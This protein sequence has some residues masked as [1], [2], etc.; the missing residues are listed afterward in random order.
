MEKKT[1]AQVSWFTMLVT[2]NPN[3]LKLYLATE[4]N[5]TF[6][7]KSKKMLLEGYWGV[8]NTTIP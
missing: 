5:F 3:N 8:P 1:L 6:Q 4:K 7:K 2:L